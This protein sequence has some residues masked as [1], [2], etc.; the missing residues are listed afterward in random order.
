M[1]PNDII[2]LAVGDSY[3][4][5]E[6]G[7][8]LVVVHIRSQY[9]VVDS[10]EGIAQREKQK[11]RFITESEALKKCRVYDAPEPAFRGDATANSLVWMWDAMT[12]FMAG[13]T[14]TRLLIW[15]AAQ[16]LLGGMIWLFAE[17]PGMEI[18]KWL[19]EY[20]E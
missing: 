18:I 9:T 5:G 17:G 7:Q 6:T 3:T 16:G 1:N 8:E 19:A 14:A 4:V 10:K 11:P 2:G 20:G 13:M 12:E 15:A